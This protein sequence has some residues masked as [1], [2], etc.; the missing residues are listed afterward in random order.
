M[1]R[2]WA[3]ED[4]EDTADDDLMLMYGWSR[5]K[6]PNGVSVFLFSFPPSL[7]LESFYLIE[8]QG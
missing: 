4:V 1:S 3:F 7:L 8:L 6:N 5:G 2:A